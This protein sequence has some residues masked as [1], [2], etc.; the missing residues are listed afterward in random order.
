M[1]CVRYLKFDFCCSVVLYLKIEENLLL[2]ISQPCFQGGHGPVFTAYVICVYFMFY[3]SYV[4]K[5]CLNHYL[6][7]GGMREKINIFNTEF[8]YSYQT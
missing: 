1:R 6:D 4:V 8:I 5:L 3:I 2:L 7:F